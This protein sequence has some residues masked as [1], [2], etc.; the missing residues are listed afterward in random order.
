MYIYAIDKETR[1]ILAVTIAN[2]RAQGI[3]KLKGYAHVTS[4]PLFGTRNE[5]KFTKNTLDLTRLW[6]QGVHYGN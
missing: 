2:S 5:L 6:I 1:N 3:K 4:V